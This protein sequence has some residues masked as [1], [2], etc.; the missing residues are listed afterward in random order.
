[1][2]H[3]NIPCNR[4]ILLR[5]IPRLRVHAAKK[6]ETTGL[7]HRSAQTP[8]VLRRIAPRPIGP[9]TIQGPSLLRCAI[10]IE[11]PL[12]RR[13]QLPRHRRIVHGDGE[14][15][16][17]RDLRLLLRSA[18]LALR[19]HNALHGRQHLRPRRL[20]RRAYV[21]LHLRRGGDDVRGAACMQAADGHDAKAVDA[22]RLHLSAGDG[23]QPH[24]GA[25]GHDDR[26]DGEVRHGGVAAA[27]VEGDFETVRS[28]HLGAGLH[29][30]GARAGGQDVLAQEDV[31]DWNVV[32]R[33]GGEEPVGDHAGGAVAVFLRGL[34]EDDQRPVPAG[35]ERG[36]G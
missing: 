36:G 7:P 20:V 6:P 14:A 31:G 34:E 25:A 29:A 1:M 23:L 32:R 13:A 11:Q 8:K 3:R 17:P 21:H 33:G 30:D 15:Q 12:E 24:H 16:R 4:P 26:V 9:E 28:G 27:A 18:R 10:I 22:A 35:A 2:I 19:T 5:R